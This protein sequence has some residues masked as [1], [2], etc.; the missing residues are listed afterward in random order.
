MSIPHG[1]LGSAIK[2]ARLDKN[3]T[4]EKL[5]EMIGIT[6]MHVKQLESERRNPSVDVLYKLVTALDLSL[7]T[8]FSDNEDAKQKLRNKILLSL[9]HCTVRE[10]EIAYATI[11]A[12]RKASIH[13]SDD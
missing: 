11:E 2:K 10:M 4:Q 6:P 1:V 3:L 7:D 13:E 5:A 9:G 12:M 8:L